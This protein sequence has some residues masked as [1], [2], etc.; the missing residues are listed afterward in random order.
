[1]GE[2]LNTDT[3]RTRV[4]TCVNVTQASLSEGWCTFQGGGVFS[5]R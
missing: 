4:K 1:M 5:F 3:L 2:R